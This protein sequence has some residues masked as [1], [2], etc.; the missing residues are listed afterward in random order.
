MTSPPSAA[1]PR[2]AAL[3]AGLLAP[4]GAAE[5]AARAGGA[6]PAGHIVLLGDSV[7]D[8]AGYLAGRGPDVL[9]NLRARLPAGWRATLLARGGAVAADVPGQLGRL[10]PDA[11]HLAVSAGGNDAGRQEGALAGP[12]RSVAEGL[13]RIAAIRERFAEDYRAMLGVVAARRLPVA[14][15]TVYDPRFAD[16]E[17]RR[18]VVVALSAFNDVITREAFAR[19]LA[20]LDLRLVCGGDEDFAGATGPSARGGA[21][22]AAAI[23]AWSAGDDPARRRRPEV[24]AGGEGG[25]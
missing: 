4:F 5:T 18:V 8:N 9:A 25:G 6:T 13:A 14:V 19:G 20:L 17:R 11:T 16:P 24:F 22:I 21:K 3:G 23:A 10:P 7:F 15:C 12:A 2:R 1:V